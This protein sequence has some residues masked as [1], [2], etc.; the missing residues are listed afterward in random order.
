MIPEILTW[1]R[2]VKDRFIPNTGRVLE[3]GSRNVNGS[4][5]SIF[6]DAVEY[7]GVDSEDGPG[8]DVVSD[9]IDFV[10]HPNNPDEFSWW[11]D[12]VICCETLE[13]ATDP[14][15]IVETLKYHLKHGGLLIVTTPG[16]GFGEHFYPRDYF[17]FMPNFYEDILFAGMEVLEITQIQGEGQTG[18]TLCG[19]ARKA[20]PHPI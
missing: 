20:T 1:L 19:I 13:H 10:A 14:F 15:A 9:G 4:P 5:R 2:S 17:R 11:F 3:I 12:L 16:N 6:T 18:P 8:V 7:L